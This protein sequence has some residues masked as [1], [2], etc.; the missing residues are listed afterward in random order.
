MKNTT[1]QVNDISDAVV[2]YVNAA[3]TGASYSF[4]QDQSDLSAMGLENTFSSVSLPPQTKVVMYSGANYTGKTLT[5]GNGSSIPLTVDFSQTIGAFPGNIHT[6]FS[7]DG[8]NMND[9]CYSF[10]L[11]DNINETC[12]CSF[13]EFTLKYDAYGDEPVILYENFNGGAYLT[14]FYADDANFGPLHDDRTSSLLVFGNEYAYLYQGNNFS[15]GV[16]AF[17][18]T[19]IIDHARIYN[20]DGDVSWLNDSASSVKVGLK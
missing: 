3:G 4:T 2:F 9:Q 17:E 11:V 12:Q 1:Q 5:I 16:S 13:F 6:A 15:D 14:Y 7:W 8:I 19:G 18:G 20:L 10:K